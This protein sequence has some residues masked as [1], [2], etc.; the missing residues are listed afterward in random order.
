VRAEGLA[1][2]VEVEPFS[3]RAGG[4]VEGHTSG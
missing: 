4:P 3:E 1:L 2:V